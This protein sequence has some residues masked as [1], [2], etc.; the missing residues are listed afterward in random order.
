MAAGF[1]G[2]APE[3]IAKTE[4]GLVR[5]APAGDAGISVFRGVPFAKPPLGALRFKAAEAPESWEG[6]RDCIGFKPAALHEPFPS[7]LYSKEFPVYY[8]TDED[9]LYLNIWTPLAPTEKLPVMVWFH[10][11]AFQGGCSYEIEFDGEAIA[12]R[13]CILVTS[14]YR[15]GAMGFFAHPA[16]SQR[17]PRGV[18]GNYG[19]TDAIQALCWL[20][21]NIAAFGGDPARITV[22]GQSAG[23]DMVRMLLG[24][25]LSQGLFRRA[26][27]QSAGGLR[28]LAHESLAEMEEKGR[29]VQRQS[30]KAMDELLRMEGRAL[31]ALLRKASFEALGMGLHFMPCVDGLIQPELATDVIMR[32]DYFDADILAGGVD[33][34]AEM[35]RNGTGG[36]SASTAQWGEAAIQNG[37]KPPYLYHF[38]RRMPGDDAGAF[39]SAELWYVFGTL[40]RCWRAYTP[41]FTMGDYRLSRAMLDYW[42][43]FAKSGDPNGPGLPVWPAYTEKERVIQYMNEARIGPQ[44]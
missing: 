18:S 32:G 21:Q 14:A 1:T 8:G 35:L 30:G 3:R 26:I 11:G 27:V 15:C 9:C 2:Y 40:D 7:P 6:L 41:G 39:H 25:P 34:D 28:P 10:G 37:H 12:R 33:G 42:T 36:V 23:G 38:D 17:D 16:L 29:R 44:S 43:N 19:L 13:G 20:K 22:F 5:G 31:D 4:Y 24:A